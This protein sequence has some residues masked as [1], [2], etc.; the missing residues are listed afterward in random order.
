MCK[1]TRDKLKCC[2]CQLYLSV[3]PVT[4]TQ[5]G[6]CCGRC[7]RK[8]QE[9]EALYE[10][11]VE[12][13]KFPCRYQNNGCM[14][15]MQ[16]GRNSL[17]THETICDYRMF[18]CFQ[19]GC[20][21]NLN[22][23]TWLQHFKENHLN[24]LNVYAKEVAIKLEDNFTKRGYLVMNN[25][26]F[27]VIMKYK[28]SF[29]FLAMVRLFLETSDKRDLT[30]KVSVRSESNS[31]AYFT[32]QGKIVFAEQKT[33]ESDYVHITMEK[34]KIISPQAVVVTV[35]LPKRHTCTE[36]F[37]FYFVCPEEHR[38]CPSCGNPDICPKCN[39]GVEVFRNSHFPNHAIA[40]CCNKFYGCK[41]KAQLYEVLQHEKKCSI[42]PCPL[43]GKGCT[44]RFIKQEI[45]QHVH[46]DHN[47][48]DLIHNTISVR[49]VDKQGV[50][51]YFF[52]LG[53]TEIIILVFHWIVDC[54]LKV[55]FD[56]LFKITETNLVGAF[57]ILNGVQKY[58]I[59]CW[60]YFIST[61]ELTVIPAPTTDFTISLK[62]E[63]FRNV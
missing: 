8:S 32:Q 36:N 30:F 28:P 19:E 40:E 57:Y 52:S 38:C 34:L 48:P 42:Y 61:K 33:Q 13:L 51:S 39:K 16:F 45:F 15:A 1:K 4:R 58:K 44:K 62:R 56:A 10:T 50:N 49:L 24:R 59:E 41:Y 47:T 27:V 5:K 21:V 37:S 11:A 20:E 17:K 7:S 46:I 3:P 22:K 60:D 14:V 9:R 12:N 54:N 55:R 29:G 31:S 35:K 43:Q 23:F 25:Q 6:F 26:I 63:D 2:V 53:G 18:A